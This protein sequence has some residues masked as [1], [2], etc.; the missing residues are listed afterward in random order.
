MNTSQT[1]W[2]PTFKTFEHLAFFLPYTSIPLYL[3][4]FIT[5][6]ISQLTLFSFLSSSSSSSS[7]IYIY[8]FLF[9]QVSFKETIWHALLLSCTQPYHPISTWE[10][11][12]WFFILLTFFFRYLL[13][14]IEWV[15]I[16]N[17][18][19]STI[20]F[21][22]FFYPFYITIFL[23]IY[24]LLHTFLYDYISMLS[25]I[26]SNFHHNIIKFYSIVRFELINLYWHCIFT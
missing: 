17:F 12:I 22:S 2:P 16:L 14:S 7:S 21:T 24:T 13:K 8:I 23:N 18:G 5:L 9:M 20:I 4:F 15:F 19:I 11:N 6:S 10:I 3:L 1:A 25:I 26:L